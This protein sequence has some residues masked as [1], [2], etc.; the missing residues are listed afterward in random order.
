MSLAR[1]LSRLALRKGMKGGSRQWLAT[2]AVLGLAS[3][4]KKRHQQQ[5]DKV[6]R[7]EVLQPGETIT[8]RVID[9]ATERDCS[10]PPIV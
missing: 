9:P 6:L 1:N 2:G 5:K 4:S 3:W 10:R 7:R 8:I